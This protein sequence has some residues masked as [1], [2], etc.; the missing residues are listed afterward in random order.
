MQQIKDK[1]HCLICNDYK[2]T[3]FENID[4]AVGNKA[5]AQYSVFFSPCFSRLL[6]SVKELNN[7]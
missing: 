1:G 2:K 6:K 5:H 7:K 3:S 4:I